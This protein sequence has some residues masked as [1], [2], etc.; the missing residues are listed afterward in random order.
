MRKYFPTVVWVDEAGNKNNLNYEKAPRVVGGKFV[1]TYFKGPIHHFAYTKVHGFNFDGKYRCVGEVLRETV[2]ETN[3]YLMQYTVPY[4]ATLTSDDKKCQCKSKG[5][6]FINN[7]P[8]V[9][10]NK[11]S[12]KPTNY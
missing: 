9:V 4:E 6:Y 12:T 2:C 1:S 5:T 11:T 3:V 10:F 8:E 7:Y